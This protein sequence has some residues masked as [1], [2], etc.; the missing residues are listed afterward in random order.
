MARC[1]LDTLYDGLQCLPG[2]IASTLLAIVLSMTGCFGPSVRDAEELVE[3]GRLDEAENLMRWLVQRE[4]DDS[5]LEK[6][7]REVSRQA[8]EA[9]FQP[10]EE[11]IAEGKLHEAAVEVETAIYYNPTDQNYR[12]ILSSLHRL[13]RET[14]QRMELVRAAAKEEDWHGAKRLLDPVLLYR[15]TFP[16]L[17]QMHE[18]V[19]RGNFDIYLREGKRFL[20]VSDYEQSRLYFE[21]ALEIFSEDDE[22]INGLEASR[23]RSQA[24]GIAHEALTLL[25]E[26]KHMPALAKAKEAADL[27]P[28][29]EYVEAVLTECYRRATLDCLAREEDAYLAGRPHVALD[30][31]DQAVEIDPP[32]RQLRERIRARHDTVTKELAALYQKTG[33]QN[34][35]QGRMAGAWV[36]YRVAASLDPDLKGLSERLQR[37]HDAV[38]P[39][40]IYRVVVLPAGQQERTTPG[41]GERLEKALRSQLAEAGLDG[42]RFYSHRDVDGERLRETGERPDAVL[43]ATLESFWLESKDPRLEDKSRVYVAGHVPELNPGLAQTRERWEQSQSEVPAAARVQEQAGASLKQQAEE[44]RRLQEAYDQAAGQSAPSGDVEAVLARQQE[45]KRLEDDLRGSITAQRLAEEKLSETTRAREAAEAAAQRDLETYLAESPYEF[46]ALERTYAFQE[47]TV[48]VEAVARATFR[49][50]DFAL[51]SPLEPVPVDA[52]IELRDALVAPYPRA[53]VPGDAVDLPGDE[54]LLTRLA[55]RLA[56]KAVN[57]LRDLLSEAATRRVERADVEA[58][59][60]DA[61]AAIHF[62]TLAWQVRNSLSAEERDSVRLRVRRLCG[63]DLENG[64]VD[65]LLLPL[66]LRG[67]AVDGPGFG[68]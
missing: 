61:F 33:I 31:L 7:W 58:E 38:E 23:A 18:E 47:A 20:T 11:L 66:R 28:E 68:N 56:G 55:E 60:G 29:S 9:H 24:R 65:R 46:A 17:D 53:N 16:E 49:L 52:K 39:R 62:L 3:A 1:K 12:A 63:L 30:W 5:T 41:A 21:K 15:D 8:A 32:Q 37:S 22:A 14:R 26:A 54:V 35:R 4:P 2:G 59:G 44:V 36:S 42:V 45:L 51:V 67:E 57:E 48:E 13:H 25:G 43:A 19:R 50:K 40:S 34:E 27:H 6:Q 64:E 10:V